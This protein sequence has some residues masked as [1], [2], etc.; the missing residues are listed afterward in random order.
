M[1]F[2]APLACAEPLDFPLC[3]PA[4]V[5][6]LGDRTREQQRRLEEAERAAKSAL[7]VEQVWAR[8]LKESPSIHGRAPAPAAAPQAEAGADSNE[9]GA[10][11][12]AASAD[13]DEALRLQETL[14]DV[15]SKAFVLQQAHWAHQDSPLPA[16]VTVHA[17]Q[18]HKRRQT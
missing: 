10:L 12:A 6:R 4:Q 8:V 18:R 3:A 1:P 16:V 11:A 5:R 7:I 15:R 13:T 14:F 2:R 9:D 17:G